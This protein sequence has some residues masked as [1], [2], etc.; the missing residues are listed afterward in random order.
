MSPE[1]LEDLTRT[2]DSM[3]ADASNQDYEDRERHH[4]RMAAEELTTL[5][6][7]WLENDRPKGGLWTCGCGYA[8]IHAPNYCPN[9]GQDIWRV[10]EWSE[11]D[12]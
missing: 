3:L 5:I 9:C 10:G 7:A 1:D 2:R 6:V 8:A 11:Y 4:F 12:N